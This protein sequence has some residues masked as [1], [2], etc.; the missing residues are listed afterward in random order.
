MPRYLVTIQICSPDLAVEADSPEE[1]KKMAEAFIDR[2]SPDYR[3]LVCSMDA[4]VYDAE[5]VNPDI[6]DLSWGIDKD[7]CF[8]LHDLDEKV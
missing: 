6:Y 5:E 8:Y 4:D 2:S 7:D 3:E 1:V